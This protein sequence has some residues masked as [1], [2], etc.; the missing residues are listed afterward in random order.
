MVQKAYID[1][2]KEVLYDD[3]FYKSNMQHL[4]ESMDN[5]IL[6]AYEK[7]NKVH[8]HKIGGYNRLEWFGTT[9]KNVKRQ[10]R[11]QGRF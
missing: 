4:E 3:R 1:K 9:G 11:K 6:D 10:K 8:G 2:V 5:V 7:V